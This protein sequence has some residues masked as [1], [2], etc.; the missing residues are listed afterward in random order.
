MNGGASA[1]AVFTATNINVAVASTSGHNHAERA[2]QWR[3][4]VGHHPPLSEHRR[5]PRVSRGHAIN[6]LE[7]QA[8]S[9]SALTAESDLGRVHVGQCGFADDGNFDNRFGGNCRSDSARRNR[10]RLT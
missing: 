2:H 3:I 10:P 6:D 1:R 7:S 8:R 4:D 5:Q 9:I